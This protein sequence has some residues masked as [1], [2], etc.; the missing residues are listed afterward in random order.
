[1]VKL[2]IKINLTKGLK[3]KLN[4]QKNEDQNRNKKKLIEGWNWKEKSLYQKEQ[5]E[6]NQKNEE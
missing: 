6:N 4:S 2:K 5:K 1:M 3:K